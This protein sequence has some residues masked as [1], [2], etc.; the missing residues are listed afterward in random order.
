MEKKIKNLMRLFLDSIR[1]YEHETGIAIRHDERDSEEF[2]DIF[3]DSED[4]FDY[5]EIMKRSDLDV[6]KE[7]VYDQ[8]RINALAEIYKQSIHDAAMV[9][10]ICDQVIDRSGRLLGEVRDVV[11]N[12]KP[13]ECPN[14]HIVMG[15]YGCNICGLEIN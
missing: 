4:A 8:T 11:R 5:K 12:K 9:A 3:L 2:V 10:T 15:E 13:E 1:D 6:I 7:Y 14:C